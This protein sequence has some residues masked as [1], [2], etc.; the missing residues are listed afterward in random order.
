MT[1]GAGN[2]V[3]VVN[4]VGDIVDEN[5]DEGIDSI[6]SSIDYDLSVAATNV[7]NVTLVEGA[8]NITV[9]GNGQKN[10]LTGNS[11][12]NI[13]DG[14]RDS[15]D[16]L[17]G[18]GGDDLYGVDE[19]DIVI[20]SLAGKAGG[21]DEVRLISSGSF[22]LGTNLENLT[23]NNAAGDANGT[24][25]ALDNVITGNE[26]ANLLDGKAGADTMNGGDGDDIYVIDN[27]G[28]VV[29]EDGGAGIDGVRSSFKIGLID[30]IEN[31]TFTGGKAVSFTG[32]LDANWI[33]GT[34]F[35]DTLLGDNGASGGADTIDG[36]KGADL[37]GGDDGADTYFVDNAKDVID[38]TAPLTIGLNTVKSTISYNLTE[39]GTT[40]RGLLSKIWSL[41]A[42][43]PSTAPAMTASM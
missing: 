7:E 29:S 33:T 15:G 12:D 35:N 36:G 30:G 5:A 34:N 23:I 38:E 4:D 43:L 20:E 16:T 26:F 3:F 25:N 9:F 40:V 18:G 32:S 10:R 1:G 14:D 2:D 27:A 19:G 28:D 11:G 17:I 37:M 21:T 13:I 31:Y 8:G 39:N 42:L 24:G 6:F 22:S 41:S